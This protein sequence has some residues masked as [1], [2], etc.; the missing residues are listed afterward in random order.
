[1]IITKMWYSFKRSP[2]N[3]NDDAPYI[4]WRKKNMTSDVCDDVIAVY[5]DDMSCDVSQI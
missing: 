2:L 1:M 5:V 3:E 4:A